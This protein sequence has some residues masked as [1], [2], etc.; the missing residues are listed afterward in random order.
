MGFLLRELRSHFVFL[1]RLHASE[2]AVAIAAAAGYKA[3]VA[4][5][6]VL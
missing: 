4:C 6:I 2:V 5:S 3:P 1:F